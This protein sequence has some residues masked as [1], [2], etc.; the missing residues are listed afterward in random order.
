MDVHHL[1][2]CFTV[3][4]Q[5][6][7]PAYSA[8]EFVEGQQHHQNTLRLAY[9]KSTQRLAPGYAAFTCPNL[10][11]ERWLPASSSPLALGEEL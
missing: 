2:C 11:T 7:S 3:A 6:L 4:C 1:D 8:G 5:P 9:S 10:L